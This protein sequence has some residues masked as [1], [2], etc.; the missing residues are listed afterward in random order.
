MMYSHYSILIS[1]LVC[2]SCAVLISLP[3]RGPGGKALWDWNLTH[4]EKVYRSRVSA[5][6]GVGLPLGK[7]DSELGESETKISDQ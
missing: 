5:K 7:Q 1:Q 3:E 2:K 6:A 4:R